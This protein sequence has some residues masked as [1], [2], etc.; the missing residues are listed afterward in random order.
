MKGGSIR[1]I[2]AAA[3]TWV[4]EQ[5][6]NVKAFL[7]VFTV[8]AALVFIKV[9]VDDHDNLFVAAEAVHALGISVLIYKL[10]NEDT[11]AGHISIIIS[12]FILVY[13]YV[14]V[15]TCCDQCLFF[16]IFVGFEV[17]FINLYG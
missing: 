11:C 10:S 15:Y 8:L 7:G 13:I 16:V 17:T 6:P 3:A 12:P 1:P 4:R 5:P 14:C 2:H 9:V